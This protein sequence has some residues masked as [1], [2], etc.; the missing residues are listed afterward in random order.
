MVQVT[1]PR[2]PCFKIALR[3]GLSTFPKLFTQSERSGFYL[4]IVEEGEVAAGDTI[5]LAQPDPHAVSVREIH[6]L[7]F[8][9]RE[10]PEGL[11]RALQVSALAPSWRQD[12][13]EY[14]ARL[15]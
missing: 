1:Q 3:M 12:L 4:R 15:A 6:H 2:I 11:R 10:N 8:F 9:D 7:R 5:E 14:L 13:E